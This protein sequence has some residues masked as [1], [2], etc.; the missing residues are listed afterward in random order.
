MPLAISKWKLNTSLEAKLNKRA[1]S[2][3]NVK[4]AQSLKFEGVVRGFREFLYTQGFTEIHT[5]RLEQKVQRAELIY[6]SWNISI[7]QLY[8]SK[9]VHSYISR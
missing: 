4:N 3:R 9:R 7:N 8:W 5:P 6:L 2:L 1:I